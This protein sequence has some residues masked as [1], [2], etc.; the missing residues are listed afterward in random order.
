MKF[1]WTL[2]IQFVEYIPHKISSKRVK[3]TQSTSWFQQ[4]AH[5]NGYHQMPCDKQIRWN[6]SPPSHADQSC[7][8]SSAIHMIT[9]HCWIQSDIKI[10]DTSSLCESDGDQMLG[11]AKNWE[12]VCAVGEWVVC[13]R[14]SSLPKKMIRVGRDDTKWQGDSVRKWWGWIDIRGGLS[15]VVEIRIAWIFPCGCLCSGY[16]NAW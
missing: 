12:V 7:L 4:P 5:L 3:N 1:G 2:V 6:L 10:S 14:R 13:V 15:L 11:W 8:H 9:I 16:I